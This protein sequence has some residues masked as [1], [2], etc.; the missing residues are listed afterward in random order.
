MN[1]TR[2]EF[3]VIRTIN[4]ERVALIYVRFGWVS[5]HRFFMTCQSQ[6]HQIRY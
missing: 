5:R 2:C 4:N 6:K 1:I 3:L